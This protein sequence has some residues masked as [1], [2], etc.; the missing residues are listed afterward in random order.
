MDER[1]IM[2]QAINLKRAGHYDE[3]RALYHSVIDE[4]PQCDPAYKDL[5]K[6]EIGSGRYKDALRATLMKIDLGIFF[7]RK[8]PR[9][10]FLI[11]CQGA[12]QNL[13]AP[14]FNPEIRFGRNVIAQG[15]TY[16]RSVSTPRVGAVALLAWAETDVYF[17]L[18]HCLVRLFPRAFAHYAIPDSY[19]KNFENALLG[20]SSGVDARDTRYAPI[21]YIAGFWLAVANIPD[22]ISTIDPI[23]LKMRYSR[24]LNLMGLE[25]FV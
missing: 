9:H 10:Q 21:F 17:Y 16:N 11:I 8:V 20:H 14:Q 15:E 7:T 6:V 13:D 24:Q 12:L 18:G 22:P 5:A 2:E 25:E 19:M 4:I 23:A 3:A 1:V